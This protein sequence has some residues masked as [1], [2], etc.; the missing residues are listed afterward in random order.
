MR[1]DELTE[2]H[3]RRLI[4]DLCRRFYTLG[5]VSGTGG[6]MSIFQSGRVYVPPSGVQKECLAEEDIFVLDTSGNILSGPGP[7]YNVSA[8]TPIFLK[9]FHHRGS[10]AVIHSHA[11]DAVL[12]T[13]IAS[14]VFEITHMEMIK[15]IVGSGYHDK[16]V[17]P[18]IENTTHESELVET[19]AE[20]MQA[21]P[22]SHAVLVRRHGVYIW[23]DNW[24]QTKVHAESY[25][26]LFEMAVRMHQIGFD[27]TAAPSHPD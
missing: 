9:T 24:K 1:N 14:D 5:W 3:P 21:Y 20:A 15:G 10:G 22:A 19:V 23:G 12:A 13:L 25:H 4:V 27:P 8:C 6:S 17:V 2:N 7:G 26:Y 18:I 11:I 16:L